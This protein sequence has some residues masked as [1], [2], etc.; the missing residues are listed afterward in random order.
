MSAQN[1]TK[2]SGRDPNTGLTK[3]TKN[4]RYGYI[5]DSGTEIIPCQYEELG[6]FGDGKR[7]A[8]AKY[9]GRYGYINP[10]GQVVV[11]FIYYA[12]FSFDWDNSLAPV[13]RQT[14]SGEFEFGYIDLK[15]N[16]RV[17]FS[18]EVAYPFSNGMAAVRKNDRYG[19]IDE[20]GSLV[21]PCQYEDVKWGFINANAWVKKNGKWGMINKNGV[22][23][24]SAP[25]SYEKIVAFD[26]YSGAADV[27]IRN[28]TYYFNNAGKS[29]STSTERKK[30]TE[31]KRIQKPTIVWLNQSIETKSPIYNVLAGVK[32]KS[33]LTNVSV[34]V[35]GQRG[36]SVVKVDGYDYRVNRQLE[37]KEGPNKIIITATN[38]AGTTTIEKVVTYRIQNPPEI[39]WDISRQTVKQNTF[40]V[41]ARI[42][43]K[44]KIENVYILLNGEKQVERGLVVVPND[45]Y[46]FVL[47][48]QITLTEGVNYIQIFARNAN[49]SKTTEK[50]IVV[51]EKGNT[52]K[53]TTRRIALVMGNADYKENGALEN[54][55]NDATDFAN[56]LES[57]GFDVIRAFNKTKIEIN[58]VVSEF[59]NRANN[60]DVALFFYAGHGKQYENLPY[61]VPV[62]AK[63]YN[64]PQIDSE[65]VSINMIIDTMSKSSCPMKIA[66]LDA[67]R[68]NFVEHYRSYG[69]RGIVGVNPPAGVFIAYSTAAGSFAQ[70]RVGNSRNSPYMMAL[71]ETLNIPGLNIYDVFQNVHDKV[72]DLTDNQQIPWNSGSI[73]GT[74]IFNK[75]RY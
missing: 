42:K 2:C 16:I 39:D 37:L 17:P 69:S 25:F 41:N 58:Q 26:Y 60:Y 6:D 30:D 66:I 72:V 1:Y 28:Y 19:F 73:S 59:G 57:L 3:I 10:N 18:Y 38:V 75:N 56:K 33:K 50:K 21:I 48:R 51:Y 20:F 74:F 40:I 11:P 54:P 27:A 24:T 7:L 35:E 65:C 46:D 45:G 49:G 47:N 5:D 64:A 55:I 67:C 36:V 29:F 53:S 62:G 34:R 63:I 32:S 44:C 22:V 61:I 43:S 15:G 9:S 70:D 52:K 71:L 8:V 4:G 68:D 23:L 12:A 31:E 14:R 13:C